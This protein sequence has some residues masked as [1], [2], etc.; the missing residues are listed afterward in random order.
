MKTYHGNRK[1]NSIEVWVSEGQNSR[2]LDINKSLKIRNHSPTGFE[3]GYGGSGPAQLALAILLDYIP[4]R[5]EKLY[6]KFKFDI[7]A[8]LPPDEWY[9][10]E[11]EIDNWLKS[12]TE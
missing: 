10:K 11:L 4:S 6:Q 8:G 1:N 3:W 2:I 5:A 7:I 9:I 12:T